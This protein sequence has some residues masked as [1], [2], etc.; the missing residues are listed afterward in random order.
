MGR[1]TAPVGLVAEQRAKLGAVRI[2]AGTLRGSKLA[3]ANVEG[4]RPT[5]ARVRETL[6]NWLA[7][8]IPGAR[9]LD[10]FAGTGALGIETL[11]RGASYVDLVELNAQLAKALS[12]ELDRLGCA[13]RASVH[14]CDSQVFLRRSGGTLYQLIYVDPPFALNLWEASLRMI[15]DQ[16]LLSAQGMVYLEFPADASVNLSGWEVVKQAQAGSVAFLLCRQRENAP[17]LS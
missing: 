14:N 6:F 1:G 10:L 5:P 3:V 13:A 8:R 15:L 9:A 11:S 16:R 4:L 12:G 2:I 17:R 7:G